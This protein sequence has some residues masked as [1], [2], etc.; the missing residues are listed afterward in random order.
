MKSLSKLCLLVG[1]LQYVTKCQDSEIDFYKVMAINRKET[2]CHDLK[3][4]F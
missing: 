3:T 4:G 2:K 1:L